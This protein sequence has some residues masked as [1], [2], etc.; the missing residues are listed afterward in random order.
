M[1]FLLALTLLACDVLCI[2]SNY[3]YS[4]EN[5]IEENVKPHVSC[6]PAKNCFAPNCSCFG[7][8][9]FGG[10]KRRLPQFVV[11]TFDDAINTVNIKT[12]RQILYG[13]NNS[14]GCPITATF[15]VTHEYNDYEFVNELY[16]RGSDIAVHSVT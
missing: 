5:V 11:L 7:H 10:D 9:P 3:E 13:R 8:V 4:D 14:N 16:N 6:D 1:L 2:N 15:F 12:Y